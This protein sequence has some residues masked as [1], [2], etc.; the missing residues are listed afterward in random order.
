MRC[1]SITDKGK[2]MCADLRQQGTNV[3][4]NLLSCLDDEE[5]GILYDLLKKIG[6]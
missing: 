4:Q 3:G 6:C 2:E 5:K 1:V